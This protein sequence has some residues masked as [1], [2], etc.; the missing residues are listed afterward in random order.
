MSKNTVQIPYSIKM[1]QITKKSKMTEKTFPISA[2]GHLKRPTCLGYVIVMQIE[3]TIKLHIASTTYLL[4]FGVDMLGTSTS[5]GT[6]DGWFQEFF[7][8]D[9]R[10]SID[11]F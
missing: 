2:S 6:T 5:A 3:H 10:R 9:R 1:F 7:G 8:K 11:V 4:T